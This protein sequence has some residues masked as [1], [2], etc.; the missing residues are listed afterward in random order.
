MEIHWAG[1]C[2]ALIP[3]LQAP[4]RCLA[5]SWK[6]TLSASRLPILRIKVYCCLRRLKGF[7]PF[8]YGGGGNAD[9][10]FD[11][12]C[13]ISGLECRM[14]FKLVL[15]HTLDPSGPF[16]D[17]HPIEKYLHP[18]AHHAEIS[19]EKNADFWPPQTHLCHMGANNFWGVNSV[20]SCQ[21]LSNAAINRYI[22]LCNTWNS[23]HG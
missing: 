14:G 17:I 11:S 19:V 8:V 16:W 22:A 13:K 2:G 6:M 7:L 23:L 5:V 20:R 12:K 18:K 15:A 4:I 1:A 21:T 10:F 9:F 3:V